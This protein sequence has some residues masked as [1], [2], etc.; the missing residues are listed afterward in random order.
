M[1]DIPNYK[2]SPAQLVITHMTLAM[3]IYFMQK[4]QV[5]VDS[6]DQADLS[7]SFRHYH[8]SL[9][10]L[11]LLLAGGTPE[12]CQ[13]LISPHAYTRGSASPGPAYLLSKIT[14]ATVFE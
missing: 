14:T 12:A 4:R 9:S 8:F 10:F 3:S 5:K 6:P 2:T 11:N 1:Y 7:R 13:A